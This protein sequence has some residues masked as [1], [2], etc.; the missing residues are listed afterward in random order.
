MSSFARKAKWERMRE[1][2][3][4][5]MSTSYL[6]IGVPLTQPIKKLFLHNYTDALL[7]FSVDGIHDFLPLL[8]G[9]VAAVD[10]D[11]VI[12]EQCTRFYVK[13]RTDVPTEGSAFVSS[14]GT[15]IAGN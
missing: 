9:Q 8:P 12:Q 10:M 5:S 15:S 13:Y 6:G 2:L 3:F 14:I 7:I 11:E 4:S 1:L